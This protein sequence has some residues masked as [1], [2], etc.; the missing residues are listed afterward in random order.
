MDS[1]LNN[2]GLGFAIDTFASK[3]YSNISFFQMILCFI[4][5]SYIHKPS[6]EKIEMANLEKL[7]ESQI[8]EL[9]PIIG[10]RHKLEDAIEIYRKRKRT[11]DD[12][13][14]ARK[15]SK[16]RA[17]SRFLYLYLYYRYIES[18]CN[19]FFESDATDFIITATKTFS[20]S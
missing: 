12:C 15:L 2:C 1:F 4:I 14:I 5:K 18:S 10:D 9:L 6:E 13:P 16:G 8:K 20:D 7:T 19:L 17:V 3:Y 11:Q